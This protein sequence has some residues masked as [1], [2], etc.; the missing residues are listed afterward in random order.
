V[1]IKDKLLR[2]KTIDPII[3]Q[4]R[5]I[6][7]AH[8]GD[9]K[10]YPENSKIAFDSCVLKNIDGIECDIV[11][12]FDNVD[13]ISHD[14]TFDRQTNYA[15]TIANTL[16]EDV[17]LAKIDLLMTTRYNKE[18]QRMMTSK[19]WFKSYAG[20]GIL[21]P[22][23]KGS[24]VNVALRTA[25]LITRYKIENSTVLH[26]FTA[27]LLLAAYN[28]N[29]KIRTALNASTVTAI[30]TLLDNHCWGV[31]LSSTSGLT[32]QNV[33][34][35]HNAGF[36]VGVWTVDTYRTVKPFVD[37]NVDWI[38]T[39]DPKYIEDLFVNNKYVNLNNSPITKVFPRY[40]LGSGF[41]RVGPN[42]AT[43]TALN[44]NRIGWSVKNDV[45]SPHRVFTWGERLDGTQ[46]FKVNFNMYV[47]QIATDLTRYWGFYW[48]MDGD[49]IDTTFV[50]GNYL[51]NAWYI[52]YRA[53]G[54]STDGQGII[55]RRWVGGYSDDLV[56]NTFPA[57]TTGNSIDIEVK[58]E[59]LD[60]VT[61][62]VTLKST[63]SGT[64]KEITYIYSDVNIPRAGFLCLNAQKHGVSF[65]KPVLT[66]L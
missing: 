52:N 21:F 61:T 24:D 8:R 49:A 28:Y 46:S 13:I 56:D 6:I 50:A 7:D 19:K 33:I 23:I 30:Q 39:N 66:L 29:N 34:D 9:S 18:D 11:T 53:K 57:Y 27:S 10:G 2:R 4:G 60:L 15:G 12:T 40:E 26:S 64:S 43:I 62:R 35:Y 16:Y 65:T 59:Y 44:P 17:M 54:S 3:S 31:H 20:K 45:D 63:K 25:E 48:G 51:F 55:G 58:V 47:H 5:L 14:N 37:K 1:I 41:V 36:K 38:T 32:A 42:N 22:E